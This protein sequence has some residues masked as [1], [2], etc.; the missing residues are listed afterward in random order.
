MRVVDLAEELRVSSEDILALLRAMG[1]PVPGGDAPVSDADVARVLARVERERRS[2]KKNVAD[3]VQAAVEESQGPARRRRRRREDDPPPEP[4]A[5]PED[6]E[7]ESPADEE[8]TLDDVASE[9]PTSVEGASEEV[10]SAEPDSTEPALDVSAEPELPVAEAPPAPEAASKPEEGEKEEDEGTKP[11]RRLKMPEAGPAPAAS[12]SPTPT[13]ERIV[14]RRARPEGAEGETP[15]AAAAARPTPAASAGPGGQVRI[16]ADGFTADGRKKVKKKG[17]KRQR[18]DQ[19]AVQ[20]NITR[21]MAELKG[22]SKKRRKKGSS[23]P[24]REEREAQVEADREV[25]E[26]EAKTVKVNEFLTVAELSELIDVSSTE[27]VGAAFKNLGLMVTINQRL[28]F[29]QLELLLDAFNFRAEREESYAGE[30]EVIEEEED[31]STL[32]HRPPVVTVMGHV[33]HGKTLLLDSI[34]K[35]NV[36][37]GESGGITQHI[38]AYHVELDD[39]RTISFLDTPGHAAFT[40]MRARGADVTDIVVLVVAADDSV[41]PQTIEA[42]S[43]ARNAGVPLVVAINKVDLPAA[44]AGKV[45]QELLQHG[46]TLEEFGGDT[47]SAEVSAKTGKGIDDL[48]ERILLQAEVLEL[49]ANPD[50]DAVGTVIEAKLD[51][52]KGPVVT[53]LVTRGTLRVGDAF[54]CGKFEGKVRALLDERGKP[55]PEVR[56]GIPVQV[57]GSSGVPQAGDTLQVMESVRAGEVAQ[58]RQRLEREKQLRIRERGVKLGDLAHYMKEGKVVTLPIV[59]KAD[60][61][62]SVQAV[63]DSLEQLSTAEVKVEIIHRA[64]GAVNESDVLL[65]ETAGAVII[66]FRVR[67]DANAR[68]LAEQNEVEIHQYDVIYEAVDDITRAMEGLLSPEERERIVGVAE[69][70]EVFKVSKVGT[71]AGCYVTQGTMDRKGRARLIRDGSVVYTGEIESLKR[72]KDDVKEVREGFECGIGIANFNDIK[73]GDVIECFQIDQVARTL[74]GSGSASGKG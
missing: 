50:R 16:Q 54:V 48:L 47:L 46:V 8:G 1:I 5:E 13:A 68:L 28:D 25:A 14:P 21:V 72:F 6:V 71:V 45:K 51:I 27:L 4:V 74:A 20:D 24:S 29:D 31:A 65:A 12:A 62:G 55:V 41:M 59:V 38:G 69:V 30:E 53:V 15:A 2:G 57:L 36:I 26:R 33:D 11:K 23:G 64:V 61:D 66:S 73:V 58:T 42:I 37:A 3:A 18:V 67:P 9:T 35:T 19:D 10:P 7:A 32:V 39:G 34:R 44:N 40:A 60:V 22:G 49:Q 70:R 63:A 43:H 17:K 56:P 52:G